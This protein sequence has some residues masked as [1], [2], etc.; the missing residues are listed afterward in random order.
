LPRPRE[1]ALKRDARFVRL[2]D[3]IWQLIEAEVRQGLK[4]G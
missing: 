4:A 1:L 2:V 3:D